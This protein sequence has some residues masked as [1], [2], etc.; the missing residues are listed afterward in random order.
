MPSDLSLG[1]GPEK[2]FGGF[3]WEASMY[4]TTNV[5]AKVKGAQSRNVENKRNIV[6]II[7]IFSDIQNIRH[8]V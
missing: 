2:G 6:S 5:V 3:F 4:L 1:Y 7:H 8:S